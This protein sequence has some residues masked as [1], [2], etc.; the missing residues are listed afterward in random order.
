M[1]RRLIL[2]LATL[3]LAAGCATTRP[4]VSRTETTLAQVDMTGLVCRYEAPT[5]SNM[6]RS[7]C[8]SPD[9]WKKYDE[10]NQAQSE[11]LLDEGSKVGI[12]R[13]GMRQ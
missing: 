7:V 5:G 11:Y 9:Q 3:A 13:F 2:G 6:K 10:A 8:A 12:G 1:A 4:V